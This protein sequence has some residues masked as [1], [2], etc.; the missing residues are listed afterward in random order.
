MIPNIIYDYRRSERHEPL[1]NELYIQGIEEYKIWNPEYGKT[2][3][4]SINKTH[5][6]IVR[7]ARD[8]EMELCL[9]FEDD[10]WFPSENG[11]EYFLR[12]MPETFDIYSAATYVDD[13]ENKHHLCGFHCYIINKSYYDKFLSVPDHLHI[14]TAI[15]SLGGNFK[16]CRPFAA[17]QRAGWSANNKQVVN[18]N[19]SVKPEDIYRG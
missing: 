11:Y 7:W 12:N 19:A 13:L 3:P 14:D 8:M 16:V 4:E 10:I 2:V 1:M 18:Y 17:L 5:K 6:A 9:I 15:D